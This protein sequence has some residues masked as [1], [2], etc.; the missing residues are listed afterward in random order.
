MATRS[1]TAI[2][3]ASAMFEHGGA[4]GGPVRL[5]I[6]FALSFRQ[7]VAIQERDHFVEHFRVSCSFDEMN[8]GIREPQEV[9]GNTRAHS[10]PRRRVPPMLDVSGDKLA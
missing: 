4:F 1:E 6:R 2:K 10:A 8:D 7:L 3:G 9:I 5:E